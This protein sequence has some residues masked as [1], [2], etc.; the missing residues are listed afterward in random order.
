MEP[1]NF[2]HSNITLNPPNPNNAGIEIDAIRA[3]TDGKQ[4]VSCWRLTWRERFAALIF[5]KAWLGLLSG[6]T[7][8]PAYII[9]CKEY[10]EES[11][12]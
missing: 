4:C 11:N 8:P 2:K 9:A 6:R 7:M 10:L 5:G 12:A 1:I 3:W